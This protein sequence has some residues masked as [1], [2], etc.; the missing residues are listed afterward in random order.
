M[1]DDGEFG[2]YLEPLDPI[3]LEGGAL[4]GPIASRILTLFSFTGENVRLKE[5]I[6][7]IASCGNNR[8]LRRMFPH[9]LLLFLLI[10][11]R[12]EIGVTTSRKPG[13]IFC[14]GREFDPPVGSRFIRA[15]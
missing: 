2:R 3:V 7:K 13:A 6:R 11:V 5:N 12:F 8:N 15:F 1:G 14:V 4:S 9:R 10:A